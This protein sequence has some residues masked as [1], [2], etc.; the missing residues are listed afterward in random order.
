MNK[1]TQT[2]RQQHLE[3]LYQKE[4]EQYCYDTFRKIAFLSFIITLIRLISFARQENVVGILITSSILSILILMY[5]L[6]LKFC[7][8]GAI[9]CMAFINNMLILLQINDQQGTNQFILGTNLAIAHTTILLIIDYK[10]A[11]INI[12]FQT[13]FKLLIAG[14]FDTQTDTCS[15][16]LSILCPLC[17]ISIIS[18]IDKQ[19]R[20]LFLSNNQ[21]ND[22][23]QLLPSVISDPFV[24]FS[25]DHNRMSFKYKNSSKIDR[26]PYC[27]QELSQ[28]DN[29]KQFFRLQHISEVSIEQFILNR[30]EKQS[31]FFDLNQFTLRPNQY[32]SVDFEETNIL[33]AELYHLDDTFLI[34]LEQSKQKALY[35]ESTKDNLI[36]LIGQH[37]QLVHNFLKKQASL[38]NMSLQ[39]ESSR[40]QL[41][42]QLKLHHLYF[43]G[44]YKI[45][46]SFSQA[47]KYFET[48]NID[49]KNV[50]LAII[51]LFEKAY[52]GINI[53]FD[54]TDSR[55]DVVHYKDMSQDFIIQLLQMS[56][57]KTTRDQSSKTRILLHT[58]SEILFVQ[59]IC[60]NSYIL[61]ENLNKNLVIR[62]YLKLHSPESE[63]RLSDNGIKIQ[64]Y[65]D[66]SQLKSLNKFQEYN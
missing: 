52:S 55:F 60:L 44:K 27:N 1:F 39:N 29:F 25:F 22:W 24:L 23:H 58:K 33:L 56:L 7:S 5:V 14:L 57:R 43:S 62:L 32:D 36:N 46:N 20:L 15:V 41:L 12:F 61:L 16:V 50:F 26:F 37:Q 47:N 49:F 30:I 64:L 35:I 8:S 4:K 48:V 19:R 45:S 17:F 42:Y 11:V 10:L 34:V 59:I 40:V 54:C 21:G 38:I 66:V 6:I 51:S 31:K 63:I 28:E 3:S 53:Q 18:T 13:T 2:F 9:F 65:K